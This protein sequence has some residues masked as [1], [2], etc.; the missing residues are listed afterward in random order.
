ML[1][2]PGQGGKRILIGLGTSAKVRCHR[3]LI[4]KKEASLTYDI[5]FV[6]VSGDNI[7]K[8]TQRWRSST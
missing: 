8:D 3:Q 7:H 5:P 1:R 6:V 4:E 2:L